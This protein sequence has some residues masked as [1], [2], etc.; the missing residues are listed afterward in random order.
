[1]GVTAGWELLA[2][3]PPGWGGALLAGL[4]ATLLIAVG[5][6]S[7]GLVLGL[8]CAVGKLS[9]NRLLG[10]LLDIY[11]TVIRSVPELVLIVLFYYAGTDLLNQ[12]LH[13]IGSGPLDVGGLSAGVLVIGLVQGAYV[14]E[15]VR[16]AILAIPPGEIEAGRAFAMSEWQLLRRVILPAMVPRALP[17]LGNLWLNATKDTALLAVVGFGEL[18]S[19]TRQAAA[20]SRAYVL[21]FGAAGLLYWLVSL[22]SMVAIGILERRVRRGLRA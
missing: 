5:G 4:S 19:A 17:G 14:T 1:M 10:E 11:T 16:G 9:G 8:G 15:V 7:I 22:S 6:Y 2:L 13:A 21:F 18:T 20:G 12:A 3:T